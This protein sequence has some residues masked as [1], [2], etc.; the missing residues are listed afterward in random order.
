M[1]VGNGAF[2]R[3]VVVPFDSSVSLVT[4]LRAAHIQYHS[5]GLHFTY[6]FE[7]FQW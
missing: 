1:S 5:F 4:R 6:S 2:V 3:G 7:R